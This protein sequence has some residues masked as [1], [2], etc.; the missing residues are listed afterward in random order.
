MSVALEIDHCIGHSSGPNCLHYHPNGENYIFCSGWNVGIGNLTDTHSQEFLRRH[1]DAITC[2][3]LSP[4]GKLIASGQRGTNSD[5]FVWDYDTKELVYSFEEHD[6]GVKYLAFSHDERMLISIGDDNDGK[7]II[8]DLSNG[9]IVAASP[10]LHPG[11]TCVS[12]GGFVKD[13]KRRNTD[14]YQI[15]T[16]GADGMYYWQ[17]NPYSGELGN[18]K[19]MGDARGSVSR[20]INAVKFSESE[21]WIYAATTS[22]DYLVASVKSRHIVHTVQA[23][24][25]GLPSLVAYR[26]G[27]I[28]G[29]GDGSV[30]LFGEDNESYASTTLDGSVVS[31]S[32]SQDMLEVIAGTATGSIFRINLQTMNYI[33]VAESHT[34]SVIAVA[35]STKY[36]DRF[37][38]ASDDATVRVWD[39]VE[40]S[41]CSIGYPRSHQP[42]GSKPLCLGF[43]DIVVSGWDDGSIIA[44]DIDTGENLWFIERAHP[45]GVTAI[46]LSHNMRFLLSGGV[47][48]E[49][50]LWELRSREL[51]SHLKEHT[52]K[53]TDIAIFEDDTSALTSSKDRC[54]MRWDLREEVKRYLI[55][56]TRFPLIAF[57]LLRSGGSTVTLSAW[58]E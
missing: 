35:F 45:G 47:G 52:Q 57:L 25:K 5:I 46:R 17:L 39:I 15:V 55:T 22:G 6:Y 19:V 12:F 54:I 20:N 33:A 51:I 31:L 56:C 11:T 41:N 58:G 44:H 8:W 43:S 26:D 13:I 37:A 21:E 16:G 14:L 27:L 28:T 53:I 24:K 36:P 1:D 18:V 29:G 9:C 3:A 32:L 50:R 10:K 4:S 48:G 38:T 7:L 42:S 49:V 40:Y 34:G 23:A 2:L 30:K